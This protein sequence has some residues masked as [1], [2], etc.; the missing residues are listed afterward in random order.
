MGK[1]KKS[2]KNKKRNEIKYNVTNFQ[3][4]NPFFF[5]VTKINLCIQNLDDKSKLIIKKEEITAVNDKIT[6]MKNHINIRNNNNK[7]IDIIPEFFKHFHQMEAIDRTKTSY[8]K[9]IR[10]IIEVEREKSNKTITLKIIQK[11][12]KEKYN[13]TISLSTISRVLRHHL[14]LHFIRV[15]PKNP[16]LN[17]KNYKLMHMIFLK[18]IMKGIIENYNII[19]VDET[20]CCLE[21]INYRD[22]VHK[23]DSIL[24]GAENNLKSRINIIAGISLKGIVH[25]KIVQTTVDSEIF[26][27]FM[28]ELKDKLTN[29]IK[30]TSLIVFDNAT[31]HKTKEVIDMCLKNELKVLTNIPYRSEFKGIEYYFGFFKN[32]YY[33]FIFKNNNEQLIKINEL[34]QSKEL[35]DNIEACYIQAFNRYI[36]YINNM[37]DE[38]NIN[39]LF[40]NL[41]DISNEDKSDSYE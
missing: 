24:K 15:K 16:R 22:W 28:I 10:E 30:K 39:S 13:I 4:K 35:N 12:Y 19:Y 7:M 37:K 18:G 23:N 3:N 20:G 38:E 5:D 6:N 9:K 27:K 1:K 26:L 34:L 33:K 2:N 11:K 32:M 14:N 41:S 8:E 25:Y 29:E 31:C 17:K 40:D 36:Q 21:N